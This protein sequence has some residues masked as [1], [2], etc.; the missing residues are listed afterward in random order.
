LHHQKVVFSAVKPRANYANS[1]KPFPLLQIL[2]HFLFC[3][4]PFAALFSSIDSVNFRGWTMA[5]T[6]TAAFT[7]LPFTEIFFWPTKNGLDSSKIY[8]LLLKMPLEEV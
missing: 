2:V 5:K 4:P 1:I 8:L 7:L 6:A 3:L